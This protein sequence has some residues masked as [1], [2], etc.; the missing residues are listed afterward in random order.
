MQFTTYDVVS[1]LLTHLKNELM[2][3]VSI[4]LLEPEFYI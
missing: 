4:N 3:Y 2:R 1:L